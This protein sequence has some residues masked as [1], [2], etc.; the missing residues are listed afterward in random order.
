MSLHVFKEV[1]YMA[2][3]KKTRGAGRST[4]W[5]TVVYPDSAPTDWLDKLNEL[6]VDAFVSPLHDSDVNATGE[7]KK[8]HWHVLINFATVKSKEQAQ[9]VFDAIEGVG[10]ERVSNFRNYSRYLCHLDNPDK[11]RYSEKDVKT[12]GALDYLEVIGIPTDKYQ[13]IGEMIDFCDLN[14]IVSY[15]QL[16]RIT[17]KYNQQ[18]FRAL[19]DN[20]SWVIKEYLKAKLWENNNEQIIVDE[21]TLVDPTTGEMLLASDEAT[22]EKTS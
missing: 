7:P 15:A 18:W 2:E 3:N 12:F 21:S 13:V 16:L 5:A 22:D 11:A 14:N 6:H 9:E 4:N 17:R 1:F 19:C 20:A 10:C 8:A